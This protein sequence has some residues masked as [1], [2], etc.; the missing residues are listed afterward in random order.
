MLHWTNEAKYIIPYKKF[1]PTK[2]IIHTINIKCKKF[3]NALELLRELDKVNQSKNEVSLLAVPMSIE[4]VIVGP[5][6]G[7]GAGREYRKK[8]MPHSVNPNSLISFNNPKHDNYCLFYAVCKIYKN[9]KTFN[10]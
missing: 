1:C 5:R 6:D 8:P 2:G 3:R 9:L 10:I 7:G 4:I